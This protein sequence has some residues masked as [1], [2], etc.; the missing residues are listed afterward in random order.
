MLDARCDLGE[1][2][3]AGGGGRR[4]DDLAEGEA[5]SGGDARGGAG[6]SERAHSDTSSI[7]TARG[8]RSVAPAPT[9]PKHQARASGTS[10][11][12][13]LSSFPADCCQLTPSLVGEKLLILVLY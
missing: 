6:R 8:S 5:D 4:G 10:A 11:R 3:S 7:P 12:P 1:E 2:G 13:A 9:V